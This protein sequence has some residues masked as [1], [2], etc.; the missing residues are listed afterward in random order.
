M[1]VLES[2]VCATRDVGKGLDWSGDCSGV[3]GG[4][5]VRRLRGDRAR[6]QV[7]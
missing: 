5:K 1:A 2:A 3:A 6:A 4:L 7:R